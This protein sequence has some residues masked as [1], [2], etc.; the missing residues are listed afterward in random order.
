MNRAVSLD[1]FCRRVERQGRSQLRFSRLHADPAIQRWCGVER[2]ADRWQTVEQHVE[3]LRARAR[4]LE[5]GG[6]EEFHATLWKL[7]DSLKLKGIVTAANEQEEDSPAL[8]HETDRAALRRDWGPELR[9]QLAPE[10]ALLRRAANRAPGE[11]IFIADLLL[12]AYNRAS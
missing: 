10:P 2:A 9:R 11:R 3:G 6:G 5:A 1:E 7:F 12:P 4:E 8:R